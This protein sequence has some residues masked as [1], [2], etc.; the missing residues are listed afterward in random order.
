ML[1]AQIASA[2]PWVDND[3]NEYAGNENTF[4]EDGL[5]LT[6]FYYTTISIIDGKPVQH[7]KIKR[8]F[9]GTSGEI[10]YKGALLKIEKGDVYY[11][12]VLRGKIDTDGVRSLT[13]LID[14]DQLTV[15]GVDILRG[16]EN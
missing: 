10:D 4:D 8:V 16:F 11:G 3:N 6:S 12:G 14:D 7:L 1:T 13:F 9:S 5:L 2:A 15:N